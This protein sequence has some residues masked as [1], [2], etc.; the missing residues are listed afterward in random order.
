MAAWVFGGVRLISSARSMLA[1]IG[2]GRNLYSRAPLSRF[3]WITSVPVTSLGM[4]S[5]VNWIRLKLKWVAS[6]SELTSN[7]LASPGTPS[8]R[9]C[10]REK[11]AT[12]TCSMTLLWPMITL[13]NSAR[14]FS[15]DCLHRST[16]PISLA[17]LLSTGMR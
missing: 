5:G 6:A 14:I 7:V 12:S 15:Y 3:S 9:A 11:I 8:S 2:P 16:A 17:E 13:D 1:K 10:P 4:R